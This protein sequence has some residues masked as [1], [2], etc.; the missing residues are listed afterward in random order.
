MGTQSDLQPL[1]N[2]HC[3]QG[4][5]I[6]SFVHSSPTFSEWKP[7][8]ERKMVSAEGVTSVWQ[9]PGRGPGLRR[10][11]LL[12]EAEGGAAGGPSVSR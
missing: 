6:H 9:P 1:E 7:G 3:E 10:K 11:R 12:A 8:R 5:S 4:M 2:L